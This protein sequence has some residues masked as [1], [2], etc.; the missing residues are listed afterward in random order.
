APPGGWAGAGAM[1]PPPLPIERV[2]EHVFAGL[3]VHVGGA[4][5]EIQRA[6]GVT[7]DGC[8]VAQWDSVLERCRAVAT[9]AEPPVPAMLEEERCQVEMATLA[10][11]AI[12]LD[13][14]HLDLR[15]TGGGHLA[16]RSEERV[17]VVGEAS[18]DRQ[19]P[20]GA[21]RA[22]ERDRRLD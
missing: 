8:R 22:A 5:R 10:G 15:V 2:A 18:R 19:E 11:L 12:E 14:R 9:G 17:Q 4:G 13:Q 1:L 21:G 7:L 20:V 6:D 3:E 16:A